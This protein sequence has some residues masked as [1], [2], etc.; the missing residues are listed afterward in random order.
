MTTNK[1]QNATNMRSSVH[2]STLHLLTHTNYP[3]IKAELCTLLMTHDKFDNQRGWGHGAKC[4]ESRWV[5]ILFIKL[6][7]SSFEIKFKSLE[8]HSTSY[9]STHYV[10]LLQISYHIISTQF[11]TRIHKQIADIHNCYE[12]VCDGG[13]Y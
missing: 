6:L 9:I 8:Y 2:G 13:C 3:Y 12:W 7:L 5:R 4:S 1:N 11:Q 10:L